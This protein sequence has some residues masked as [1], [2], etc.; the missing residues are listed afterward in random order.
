MKLPEENNY[1][2]ILQ[3]INDYFDLVEKNLHKKLSEIVL[4]FYLIVSIF[5]T[6]AYYMNLQIPNNFH[7]YLIG[8]MYFYLLIVLGSLEGS[9]IKIIV[10]YG[11]FVS[12]FLLLVTKTTFIQSVIVFL[13]VSLATLPITYLLELIQLIEKKDSSLDYSDIRDRMYGYYFLHRVRIV[14]I[15]MYFGGIYLLTRY[16][17]FKLVEQFS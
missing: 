13:S 1:S 6:I 5:F 11:G 7:Y 12:L 14:I 3:K 4:V 2:P 8:I 10:K 17:V 16:I 15:L 9:D